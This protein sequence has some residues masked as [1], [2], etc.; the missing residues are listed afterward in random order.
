[1]RAETA[2]NG[3]AARLRIQEQ[4]YLERMR[5]YG[6]DSARAVGWT[7]YLQVI[8]FEKLSRLFSPL[9]L[10]SEYTLLD[11]GSGLGDLVQYLREH[12]YANLVYHG[13]DI[14]PGMVRASRKKYPGTSFHQA[15]F[16]SPDFSQTYDF[17]VCS[18]ALN[19]IV[20]K[21]LNGAEAYVWNFIRKMYDLSLKGC[22]FNLLCLEGRDFFPE[23]SR[24]FYTDRNR[25]FEYCLEFCDDAYL[26][27]QE[28]E[29]VFTVILRR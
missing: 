18:G 25:V 19:I 23:D 7:E 8:L 29:F 28:H 15:D 1:M 9:D 6:I 10:R 4:Y 11:V 2:P 21:S 3:S 20:A 12:G 14:M 27:F 26:D 24:F 13:V 5:E 16:Y 17:I 22:A